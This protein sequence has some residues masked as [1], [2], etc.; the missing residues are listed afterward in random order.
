[1]SES[2]PRK[3]RVIGLRAATLLSTATL[4]VALTVGLWFVLDAIINRNFAVLESRYAKEPALVARKIVLTREETQ[5]SQSRDWGVWNATWEYMKSIEAGAPDAVYRN[6]NL[7]AESIRNAG[8]DVVIYLNTKNAIVDA[9][10]AVKGTNE[11]RDP[12]LA[13]REYDWS[14][15]AA[16]AQREG[17]VGGLIEISGIPMIIGVSPI[18]RAN[19]EGPSAGTIAMGRWLDEAHIAQLSEEIGTQVSFRAALPNDTDAIAVPLSN[20][21]IAGDF[22]L[23]DAFGAPCLVGRVVIERDILTQAKMLRRAVI[24]GLLAFGVVVTIAVYA[25][26]HVLIVSRLVRVSRELLHVAGCDGGSA[27]VRVDRDDELGSLIRSMNRLI[28]RVSLSNQETEEAL[29]EQTIVADANRKLAMVAARTDNAVVI[30]DATGVIE[31]VNLAFMRLTGYSPDESIGQR[32]GTLLQGEATC[33]ETRAEIREAIR[34]GVHIDREILNYH[35]DGTPYWVRVSI[36]PVFD[37]QGNIQNFIAIES[38]VSERR[39]RERELIEAR[40]AAEDAA[41]ARATFVANVSHEIRTPLNGI[42]GFAELLR[43][44]ADGDHEVD[45]VE[46]AEWLSIIH[47]SATHL[48]ELINDVLDLSKLQANRMT[49]EPIACV[50]RELV[51]QSAQMHRAKAK[52]KGLKL[53]VE[54]DESVPRLIDLDP[55]RLRQL[56]TNLV[57]NAVKFTDSGSVRIAV[58]WREEAIV[59]VSGAA[60]EAQDSQV[61]RADEVEPISSSRLMIS[62]ID[63]GI[64]ISDAKMRELFTPF[65]QGDASITRRFGGTGLGLAICKGIAE[66][67]SGTIR[68]AS[69][70]GKGTRIYLDLPA[71][72]S[73]QEVEGE[74]ASDASGVDEMCERQT[75]SRALPK[76]LAGVNV[77]VVDDAIVNRK[78]FDIV[79]REAGATVS[80]ADNGERAV[81]MVLEQDF[82]LVLMDGQMPIMDG[83]TATSILRSRGITIP[84]L[85]LTAHAMEHDA[86]RFIEAGCDAH[87]AKPIAPIKLVR[88]VAVHLGRKASAHA[89]ASDK[90]FGEHAVHEAGVEEADVEETGVANTLAVSCES[91]KIDS[92]THEASGMA[93]MMLDEELANDPELRAIVEDFVRTIP[94]RAKELREAAVVRDAARLARL[95]HGLKGTSAT[96]GLHAVA[97]MAATVERA[98]LRNDLAGAVAAILEYELR[99]RRDAA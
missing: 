69:E 14:L 74:E 54:V 2:V 9:V 24:L 43:S 67:M 65:V 71:P 16:S 55:T 30:T 22:L 45:E 20:Y 42:L 87:L 80:L 29:S 75:G 57:G 58:S 70:P 39:E 91:A 8:A 13:V 27:T 78:L 40:R 46:R 47:G 51:S 76:C 48:L 6:E 77:L 63:T 73:A 96:L 84:I 93:D 5:R 34:T 95:A 41:S 52:D 79:L 72:R 1:M 66:A 56:I 36:E 11:V 82:D 10:E 92:G 62:V 89:D 49:V 23:N 26:V 85:A 19:R 99:T 33:E 81:A 37:D 97:H 12:G 98:A 59:K 83:L 44:A 64:G 7:I 35:K 18:L 88:A 31:W 53:D 28:E 25:S 15:L 38:D 21:Q 32:P 3:R 86:A 50:V 4:V 60:D 17:D 90:A 94:D 68:V 61:I